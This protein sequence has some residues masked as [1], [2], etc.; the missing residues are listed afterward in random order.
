MCFSMVEWKPQCFLKRPTCTFHGFILELAL[1]QCLLEIKSKCKVCS[2]LKFAR[3]NG[4][5]HKMNTKRLKCWI[6]SDGFVLNIAVF[7]RAVSPLATVY[8]QK[9]VTLAAISVRNIWW[10]FANLLDGL[11]VKHR[12]EACSRQQ[13][14]PSKA[15]L[16]VGRRRR[17]QRCA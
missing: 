14:A 1:Y 6:I 10:G 13:S 7:C 11:N 9:R 15:D 12:P 17:T 16:M 2:W 5:I 3:T 4:G 8:S